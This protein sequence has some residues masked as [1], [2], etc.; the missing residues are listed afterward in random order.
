MFAAYVQ[1]GVDKVVLSLISV[2]GCSLSVIALILTVL[3]Y[4]IYWK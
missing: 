3:I 1:T 4:A 2:V